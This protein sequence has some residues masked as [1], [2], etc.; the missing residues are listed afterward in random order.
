MS[1]NDTKENRSVLDKN[2]GDS[3]P[4][5]Y[6]A[7]EEIKV[8]E[9][10]ITKEFPIIQKNSINNKMICQI[11][12]PHVG[13]YIIIMTKQKSLNGEAHLYSA[14][15]KLLVDFYFVNENADGECTIYYKSGE[16]YFSGYLYHG[17]RNGL[18]VEYAKDGRSIYEGFYKNGCRDYKINKRKDRDNFW[19]VRDEVGNLVSICQKD[20]QGRN[21]GICYFY[22]NGCI[23]KISNWK[24]GA[25]TE[26]LSLFEGDTMKS[27]TNGQLSYVGGYVKHDLDYEP[28]VG[29]EKTAESGLK[30]K[31]AQLFT[32]RIGGIKNWKDLT[33]MEKFTLFMQFVFF[34]FVVELVFMCVAFLFGFSE[35][36]ILLGKLAFVSVLLINFIV[37]FYHWKQSSTAFSNLYKELY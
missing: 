12:K 4:S 26:V 24:H 21:H 23:A 11:G 3:S 35:F 19:N 7:N 37:W 27:Y 9:S 29:A 20:T 32:F 22:Q 13:C 15:G 25:E 10:C 16:R 36:A 1:S 8:W 31:L 2:L 17:Y 14:E 18:G 30:G 33:S 34:L 5:Y 28:I 6:R